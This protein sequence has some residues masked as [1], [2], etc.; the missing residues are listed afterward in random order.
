V[1]TVLGKWNSVRFAQTFCPIWMQFGARVD[2][3]DNSR[4]HEKSA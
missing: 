3:V 4:V 1:K 2:A